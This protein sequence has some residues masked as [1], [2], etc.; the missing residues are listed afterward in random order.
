[1]KMMILVEGI[2]NV[3]ELQDFFCACHFP[4]LILQEALKT[5]S[6]AC[7]VTF[8]K[9]SHPTLNRTKLILTLIN[10]KII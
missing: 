9:K 4:E 6:T 8:S 1:M 5:I 7:T 3:Y 10:S 2:L